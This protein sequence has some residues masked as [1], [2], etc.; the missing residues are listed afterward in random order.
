MASLKEIKGRIASVGNTL[1]ITSAMKMVS[2]A[3]L[4]RMQGVAAALERYEERL[5]RIASH[6]FVPEGE[7]ALSRWQAPR[8]ECRKVALVAL[9]SDSSLCGAFN[10]NILRKLKSELEALNARGCGEVILYPIGEKIAQAVTREGYKACYD[11]RTLIS[12]PNYASASRAAE[13]LMERYLQGEFDAIYILHNHFYSLG[14]QAPVLEQW[15]PMA[16][17]EGEADHGEEYILE[18]EATLLQRE[19]LPYTL[20]TQFYSR[21][22]DSAVAEHAARMIAMQTA[23]DNAS[24]LLEELRLSY[25]KRR[26]QAITEEL[27]DIA[28]SQ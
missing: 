19:L 18:P 21:L 5:S 25:N 27:S 26:Q 23:S 6:L 12:K 17:S 7:G 20:R 9:S 11:Y 1:K 15:L 2:S 10:N 14:K 22:L 16:L 3:K 24:N 13:E 8:A 28:Q 4:H